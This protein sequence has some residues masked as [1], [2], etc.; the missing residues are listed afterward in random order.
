MFDFISNIFKPATELI[1]ELHVSDEERGKLQSELSKVQAKMQEESAKLMIAEASSDHWIVAAWRPVCA[2]VL[3]TL[4]LLDGFKIVEAPTQVYDLAELFL[5][6]YG[7]GRSLEK[8]SKQI[9]KK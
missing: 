3:F 6:V 2:I 9:G 5:G 1:D 4:I 7:G 8:I